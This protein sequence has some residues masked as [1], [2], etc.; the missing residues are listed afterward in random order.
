M[1]A[2]SILTTLAVAA[3][4]AAAPAAQAQAQQGAG[5]RP[6]RPQR[7]TATGEHRPHTHPGNAAAALRMLAAYQARYR[8]QHGRFAATPDELGFP[9]HAGVALR[10]IPNAG[11]GYAVVATSAAQECAFFHGE[12]AAP[13]PYASSP[14]TVR[15]Q[16]RAQ[17]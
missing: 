8:A 9:P 5:A 16:A 11:R 17:R 2:R 12:S 13:R 3:A 10:I 6:A 14:N 4:L 7:Q 1:R 15:C